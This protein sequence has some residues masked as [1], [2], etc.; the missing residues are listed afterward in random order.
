MGLVEETGFGHMMKGAEAAAGPG[1]L[2]QE[3]Q[4]WANGDR[5]RSLKVGS[6]C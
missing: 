6:D 5:S 4:T 3:T 1:L 2:S